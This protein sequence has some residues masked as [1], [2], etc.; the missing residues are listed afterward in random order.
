MRSRRGFDRRNVPQSS[1][2]VLHWPPRLPW[3][4]A[5][6]NFHDSLYNWRVRTNIFLTWII[7]VNLALLLLTMDRLAWS[8]NFPSFMTHRRLSDHCHV[9]LCATT[10]SNK[11]IRTCTIDNNYSIS[12][13]S[14]SDNWDPLRDLDKR[15]KIILKTSDEK[16]LYQNIKTETKAKNK[17]N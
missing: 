1:L 13:V 10:G 5:T 3:T 15:S 16:N 17:Y 11:P 4:R 12:F 2:I 14:I 6:V 8:E 7:V 9:S